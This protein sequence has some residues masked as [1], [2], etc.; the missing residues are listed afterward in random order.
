M[1]LRVGE[2]APLFDVVDLYGRRVSLNA[3]YGNLVLISFYRSAVCPLCNVR[4]SYLLRRAHDYQR[5]GVTIISFFESFPDNAHLYLDRF[6][7]PFPIV[8][9]GAADVYAR[10]GLKTS[11]FGTARGTLRRS[12]YHEARQ[13]NLGDWRLLPGFFA[14][15]GKKFRMPAEFLLGPDLTVRVAYYGHDAGDFMR[16]SELDHHIE[17]VRRDFPLHTSPYST[18][19][20]ST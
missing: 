4:L 20:F 7:A 15:D 3:C 1:R 17:M 6:R 13:R 11:W 12:I 9:D 5:A 10:Y 16:F 18:R 19:P 14:M 2:L 8:A